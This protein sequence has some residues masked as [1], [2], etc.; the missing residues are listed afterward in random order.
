MN[1]AYL[2]IQMHD[3]AVVEIAEALQQLP[4]TRADL[5]EYIEK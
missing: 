5:R 2:D 3:V 4:D 1:V